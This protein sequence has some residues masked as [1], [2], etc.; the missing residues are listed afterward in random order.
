MREKTRD[1]LLS[2]DTI[3]ALATPE[4]RSGIGVLRL[5]GPRAVDLVHRFFRSRDP[6]VARRARLGRFLRDDDTVVDSVVVTVFEHPHSYTGEHVA[7]VSAHGNPLILKEIE[8]I[9]VSAGA[10]RAR[11]GEFT[12]R[13]VRNGKM[14]LTQAEAVRDFVHAETAAQAQTAMRQMQGALSRRVKP[15][16]DDL[17]AAVAEL[18]AGIDFAEDDV[19]PPAPEELARRIEGLTDRVDALSSSFDYGRLLTG[20][21][22]VAFAG[23]PNVGKSSLFNRLVGQDRAIVTEF[24]GT[25]RDVLTETIEIAGIPVRVA[26]TAGLRETA[27]TVEAI[28]VERTRTTLAEADLR[29]LVLDGSSELTDEDC[30]LLDRVGEVPTIVAINKCDLAPGWER[31]VVPTGIPTSALEN[32]GLEELEKAIEAWIL[33]RRPDASD[34]F[35]ITSLRQHRALLET[36]EGLR[37]GASSLRAGVPH[38]LI[39]VELY[40]ALEALGEVTGEITNED[41]LDHVFSAFC[42]GK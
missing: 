18:E 23:R 29:V 17:V 20:G 11:R 33:E 16:R 22:F 35:L 2:D 8:A 40:R 5:S 28:G 37:A 13:A 42:I 24:P 25:T 6:Y 41:I 15:L 3:A 31:S 27:E 1:E 32:R 19:E 21:L 30:D 9:L 26:D 36:A 12:L 10:R 38:E 14:D 7:E 4:G 39:L 34:G